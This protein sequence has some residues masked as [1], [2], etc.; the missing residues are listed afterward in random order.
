MLAHIGKLI[1]AQTREI[2]VAARLGGEEFVVLLPD[3]D[4]TDADAFTQRVRRALASSDDSELP[5]VRMSAGVA[6]TTDPSSIQELLLRAD[7]A[8]YDAKRG[9][10]NKTTIFTPSCNPASDATPTDEK[11][12]QL[13]SATDPCSGGNMTSSAPGR[14]V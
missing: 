14:P 1:A 5:M 2:D 13:L 11:R 3:C 6:A 8:L 10:R 9:G 7:S 4:P 12:V